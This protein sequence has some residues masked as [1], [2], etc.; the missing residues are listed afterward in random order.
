MSIETR[1]A[2]ADSPENRKDAVGELQ[3]F[4]RHAGLEQPDA[5]KR[6]EWVKTTGLDK[7][8][9]VLSVMNG[10]LRGEEKFQR[11][12]GKAV[13]SVVGMGGT[14]S[15]DLEPPEHAEHEFRELV[16]K[17]QNDIQDSNIPLQAARL[18]AGI[19]FAHMF[20][21]GNGRTARSAYSL[22]RYGEL[23][24]EKSF[25]KRGPDVQRFS[26]ALNAGGMALC[27]KKEGVI[28]GVNDPFDEYYLTTD[29]IS[30]GMTDHLKYLAARRVIMTTQGAIPQTIEFASLS[31]DQRAA[32][33]CEYAAIR[34]EFFWMT[35]EVV[36]RYTS[37][38]LQMLEDAVP[39][40]EG[41][42]KANPTP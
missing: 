7:L 34:K 29:G 9:D 8:L 19:I 41:A 42:D 23:P 39:H 12:E 4:L 18:Y 11:W 26:E 38:V 15:V 24:D 31:P 30:M 25:V 36:T 21:D 2:P 16:L 20:P 5:S 33:D 14:E 32:F 27:F 3:R 22:I 37:S 40:V 1:M 17:I 6:A 10:L 28:E 13:K 35:Q